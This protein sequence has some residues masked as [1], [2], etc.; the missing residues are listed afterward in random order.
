[1]GVIQHMGA[2]VLFGAQ[3]LELFFKYGV[4]LR[5]TVHQ[6]YAV[7][8]KSLSI[9]IFTGLFV[10]AIMAIEI[11]LQLRDF[12]AQG[13]LGGLATS[14]TLRNIG[15]VLIAFLLSGK[16]GAYTAAELGTMEVTDQL[17][18]IRCLGIN[19]LRYI[20]LPRMIAIIFSSFLLLIVGLLITILGGVLFSSQNL[21]INPLNYIQNIPK[22]VSVTSIGVGVVKSFVFGV[23]ISVI[24]CYEG[25]RTRGGSIGVGE[26]VRRTSVATLLAIIIADFSISMMA[27]FLE[28]IFST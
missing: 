21:G 10:G 22:L 6:M 14:V 15:P 16:V 20:V 13:F 5:R 8:V 27:S 18:A 7:G 24:C 1:M 2:T 28:D 25:Y 26:S 9:T 23:L 11:N 12:G 4:N 19:P 17:N 3:V